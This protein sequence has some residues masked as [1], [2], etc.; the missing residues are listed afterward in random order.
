[1]T[2]AYRKYFKASR[3]ELLWQTSWLNYSLDM[4]SIPSYESKKS[5][6]TSIVSPENEERELRELLES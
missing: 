1:M 3:S 6:E 5:D 4:A 2:G